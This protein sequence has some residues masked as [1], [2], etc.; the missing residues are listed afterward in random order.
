MAYAKQNR[1]K[2][3]LKTDPG[4][5][6]CTKVCKYGGYN[7]SAEAAKAA[8]REKKKPYGCN[9]KLANVTPLVHGKRYEM[10]GVSIMI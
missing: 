3:E 8:E 9:S 6:G 10:S 5:A 1:G 4:C 2:A 7:M